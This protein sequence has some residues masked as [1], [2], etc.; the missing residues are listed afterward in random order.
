MKYLHLKNL[1]LLPLWR[2]QLLNP[3]N[4]RK[5]PPPT[6]SLLH[7]SKK[8]LLRKQPPPTKRVQQAKR[9][10]PRVAKVLC[11][12]LRRRPLA[13]NNP[14]SRCPRLLRKSKT[15][16]SLLLLRKKRRR[17]I[18][19]PRRCHPLTASLLQLRLLYRKEN[20]NARCKI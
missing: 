3:L 20:K 14:T 6:I 1:R 12:P 17:K 19:L 7:R 9:C 15:E 4:I 5:L 13:S 18:L 2:D 10:S 16:R 8:L 11:L